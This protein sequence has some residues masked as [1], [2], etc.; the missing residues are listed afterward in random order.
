MIRKNLSP[1]D[2]EESVTTGL[3]K[4]ARPLDLE[5]SLHKSVFTRAVE[6]N[7]YRTLKRSGAQRAET[8]T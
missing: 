4:I 5:A 8:G 3:K 1:I 7:D 2:F 6:C